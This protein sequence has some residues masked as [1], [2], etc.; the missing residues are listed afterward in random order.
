MQCNINYK[1]YKP[2]AGTASPP[3]Y[4]QTGALCRLPAW[5]LTLPSL[6][7]TSSLLLKRLSSSISW[8]PGGSLTCSTLVGTADSAFPPLRLPLIK[9]HFTSVHF[10]PASQTWLPYC[11]S[12]KMF[13]PCYGNV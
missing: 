11:P 8:I 7:E 1:M 13:L 5:L 4:S 2:G 6:V 10:S 3:G 12:L 9:K